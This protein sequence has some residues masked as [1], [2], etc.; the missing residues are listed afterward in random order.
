[1]RRTTLAAALLAAALAGCAGPSAGRDADG[2][3]GPPSATARRLTGDELRRAR[4]L[5]EVVV[6]G[7]VTSYDD[8]PAGR[9]YTVR[10]EEVLA[11]QST[12]AERAATHPM[13]EGEVLQVS[14]FLFRS[15]GGGGEVGALEELSRYVFFL[16]PT[17]DAGE[18]LNLEDAAALRLPGAQATLDELRVLR[19]RQEAAA[20]E[21]AGG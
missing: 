2:R 4:D 1:M 17:D 16:S 14:A 18:W 11:R 10:V 13:G 9:L 19:E 12:L 21:R 20:R 5:A 7:T 8:R 6:V 15:G 3:R